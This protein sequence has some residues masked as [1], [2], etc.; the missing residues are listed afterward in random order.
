[1]LMASKS[2]VGCCTRAL[3][4]SGSVDMSLPFPPPRHTGR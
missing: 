4:I 2:T 1:V 3:L